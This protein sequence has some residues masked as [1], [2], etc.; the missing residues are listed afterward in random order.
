MVAQTDLQL[1][2]HTPVA[3]GR[4][5]GRNRETQALSTVSPAGD[6]PVLQQEVS[7]VQIRGIKTIILGTGFHKS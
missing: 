6:K 4:H 3:A 1:A 2:H 5:F 7:Q